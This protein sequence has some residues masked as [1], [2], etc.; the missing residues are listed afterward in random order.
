MTIAY[1]ILGQS[2]PNTNTWTTVYTVPS[3]NAAIISTISICNTSNSTNAR[4]GL[5]VTKSGI[6]APTSRSSNTIIVSEATVVSNDT[7]FLTLG[8]T[9][10][11]NDSL[12][13]N[14]TAGNANVSF[15]AFGSEI[16]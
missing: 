1:K 14:V 12:R 5:A 3:G 7:A 16:Y 6:S 4:Y 13:A 11:A 9:L 8:I 2:L 15:N 10:G